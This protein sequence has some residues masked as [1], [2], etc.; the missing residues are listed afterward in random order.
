MT[1]DGGQKWRF[2]GYELDADVREL[3]LEGELVP[4]EP[5]VFDLLCF[6]VEQ[7]DRAVNK[8]D[9]Q[10]AIWRGVIVSE[11]ALTRAI[12]KARRAIGD[13]AD[14][15]AAIR[16]VHG[17]GY[18]FVAPLDTEIEP[19]R[20]DDPAPIQPPTPPGRSTIW[21]AAGAAVVLLLAGLAWQWRAI[22]EST[23]PV[24]VA[25]LPIKNATGDSEYD[26]ARLGLMSLVTEYIGSD[27]RL[28]IAPA[29][30]TWRVAEAID[31][32]PPDERAARLRGAVGAS[33]IVAARLERPSGSL[34][35]TYRVEG[36]DG[37][38]RTYT[39]FGD[40]PPSLARAMALALIRDLAPTRASERELHVV[41]E[42]PFVNEAYSR[43]LGL[44]LEGRCGEAQTLF[45]VVSD[46]APAF[47]QAV[48]EWANCASILGNN[49]AAEQAFGDILSRT[50]E[51]SP[52][53]LRARSL[54]GLGKIF[55][56]RGNHER[57]AE[58]YNESLA[59]A[60]ALGDPA[61][62]GNALTSLAYAMRDR[63]DI[64][65]A[66]LMLG[67]AVTAF[68]RSGVGAVPGHPRAAMANMDMAEGKLDDAER[69]L[70]AA[71]EA[72]RTFGDRRNEA[73]M[74]NNYGYL[75]RLQG[76]TTE[77]EPFHLE[78]LAIRREIGDTVGVG[79]ILGMLSVLYTD[80]GRL[81][82]AFN[83]ASEAFEIAESAEDR[84]YMGTSLAQLGDIFVAREDLDTA[85]DYYRRSEAE[86]ATMGDMARAAQA[87]LRLARID[88][89]RGELDPAGEK[90]QQIIA[91]GQAERYDELLI[92]AL[93]LGG[94]IDVQR[95]ALA[96]ASDHYRRA[97][98]LSDDS[99][100][101]SRR[102]ALVRKLI[103]TFLSAD[104]VAAA[105]PYVGLLSDDESADLVVTGRYLIAVGNTERA[106]AVLRQ[107]KRL[108]GATWSNANQ[109]WLDEIQQ[110]P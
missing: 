94:D 60:E 58:L 32:L 46:A 55:H 61:L 105:E 81:D 39:M 89:D 108:A 11:T 16:T 101:V 84:R 69:N 7:R 8:D 85:A 50:A 48:Y 78:S 2:G 70:S 90:T 1:A 59:E 66:R 19:A 51:S 29:S 71:L 26:Y 91:L 76:R 74:L 6:L 102:P 9:I 100:F 83:V 22:S 54:H 62:E 14:R 103:E 34:Q 23:G 64:D 96:A 30:D 65:A 24:R 43:A 20:G 98:N 36:A 56:R 72:F 63:D 49:A 15:Q 21:L 67:R 38:A 31:K 82:E 45:A 33:H 35:M 107:A 104:D 12:M 95:G 44:S 99:G 27:G 97:L 57:A 40:D 52:H 13:S 86:F 28:A 77:A 53:A 18:Q 88:A 79:R 10:A 109:R 41:A 75:R 80:A 47:D 110:Q 17:H 106:L 3:R 37:T 93:E 92:E 25:V 42:D 87:A 5:R 4:L 73:M 68:R